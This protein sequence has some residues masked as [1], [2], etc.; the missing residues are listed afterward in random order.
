ML[1]RRSPIAV[2]GRLRYCRLLCVL[3]AMGDHENSCTTEMCWQLGACTPR[4]QLI[5]GL[6]A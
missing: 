4:Q 3:H 6:P 2:A 1:R 5:G